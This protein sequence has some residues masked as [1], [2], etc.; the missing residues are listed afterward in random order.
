MIIFK[1][2]RTY[3][4]H[5]SNMEIVTSLLNPCFYL[6][7][8]LFVFSTNC[9]TCF[10]SLS[11]DLLDKYSTRGLIVMINKLRYRQLKFYETPSGNLTVGKEIVS[12]VVRFTHQCGGDRSE[13]KAT[14][15]SLS[16]TI[17][18]LHKGMNSPEVAITCWRCPHVDTKQIS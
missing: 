14:V 10:V 4:I 9:L 8:F 11:Q 6:I 3:S 18:H 13:L 17:W 2:Y 15:C 12:L 5:L 16:F 7:L 1:S